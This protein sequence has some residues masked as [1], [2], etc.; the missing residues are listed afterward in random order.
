[1]KKKLAD[2]DFDCLE[3][4]ENYVRSDIA[5]ARCY[6]HLLSGLVIPLKHDASLLQV[7]SAV[8]EYMDRA[9]ELGFIMALGKLYDK[10]DKPGLH[11][12]IDASLA[13]P[14]ESAKLKLK[15]LQEPGRQAALEN[16]ERSRRKL[17]L[18]TAR[19]LRYIH[20]QKIKKAIGPLRNAQRAH[21]IPKL[22][23]YDDV[24]WR[25]LRRWLRYAEL[26]HTRA[27]IAAGG[28][29]PSPGNFMP[30]IKADVKNFLAKLRNVVPV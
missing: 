6:D 12:L 1:M 25:K 15:H 23:E 30:P 18:E 19:R 4:I 16:M 2:P 26:L 17:R 10:N 8:V 3:V 11:Q 20:I 21:N 13:V 22:S 5:E 28:S 27:M 9:F 24:G 29:S 7:A 14:D